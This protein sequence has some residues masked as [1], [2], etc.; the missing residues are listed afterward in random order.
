MANSKHIAGAV[1]HQPIAWWPSMSEFSEITYRDPI[2]KRNSLYEMADEFPPR[3]LL[4]QTGYMD[5]RIGEHALK[6]LVETLQESY[7]RADASE[8]LTHEL[9]D[10]PGHSGG[11]PDSALDSVP[12]WLKRQGTPLY[13]GE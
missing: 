5:E 2:I 9:M 8:Q 7:K 3:P 11:V 4:I 12:R 1:A 6:Q 13:H 10:I